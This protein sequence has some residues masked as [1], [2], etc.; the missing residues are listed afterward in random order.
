MKELSCDG[1]ELRS[2][3]LPIV[4]AIMR[5]AMGEEESDAIGQFQPVEVEVGGLLECEP[6]DTF[7]IWNTD[8]DQAEMEITLRSC[9]YSF[10]TD[11][12]KVHARL[13]LKALH[14]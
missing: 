13:N 4:C 10:D 8:S 2:K 12:S 14:A 7:V 1:L 11:L 5:L 9:D 6:G 3:S